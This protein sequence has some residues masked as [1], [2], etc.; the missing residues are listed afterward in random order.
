[1]SI[2]LLALVS[3]AFGGK[4]GIAQYN[5]DLLTAVASWGAGTQVL[6]L[7]RLGQAEPS[8]L[9]PGVRQVAPK[10]K[11]RFAIAA[12]HAALTQG[13][14]D[15]VF[16]GHVN[17]VQLGALVAR[18]LRVPLW[19]QLHGR[20]AWEPLSALQRQA[21]ER[22][23]LISVVSRYT[24][25]RFLATSRI[26]RWRV[27]VVPNTVR[28]DF[29]PGPK[30]Q[31]VLDRHGL[32]GRTVLLTVGR[33]VA[34]ERGKGHD[35]IIEALPEL[36]ET[37]PDLVY[38]IVGEGDDR[39]RLE[40]LARQAGIER[41]VVFAGAVDDAKL[42]DYYRA[43]DGFVMPSVQEGFG[44]V[45]L[46]AAASGL[47]VIGGN[48]DGTPD[49][50]ADGACGQLIDPRDRAQLVAAIKAAVNG[51]PPDLAAVDRY[52]FANFAAQVCGLLSDL[53]TADGR[54]RTAA[55]SS[56]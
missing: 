16:C 50:L 21:A 6:V 38:L 20:E 13:P 18:L 11:V 31:D 46:E 1:M 40:A 55:T 25:R 10:G 28:A 49:A 54:P 52:R 32:R 9:P 2:N 27:R 45:F 12:L 24:R 19:L 26:E 5:R 7:P 22:A 43:A 33:I 56:R 15:V 48:E 14:F 30:S 4:G 47:K 51:G 8:M 53:T 36:L 39:P 34:A 23:S 29:A 37:L 41:Q 44:I 3:D 42:P 17:L 35:R